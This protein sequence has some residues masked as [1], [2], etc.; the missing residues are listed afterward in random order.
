[1]N[2]HNMR[3]P[4]GDL[5]KVVPGS[6]SG[7]NEGS[8]CRQADKGDGQCRNGG[9][10]ASEHVEARALFL[11][12]NISSK[13]RFSLR[14]P[15]VVPSSRC[16]RRRADAEARRRTA[17]ARHDTNL[18]TGERCPNESPLLAAIL[19]D[20]TNL[21][22]SRR[23]AASQGVT[24]TNSPGRRMPL[25][26]S[27]HPIAHKQLVAAAYASNAVSMDGDIQQ[28]NLNGFLTSEPAARGCGQGR[29]LASSRPCMM[30]SFHRNQSFARAH[31]RPTPTRP[32]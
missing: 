10:D 32:D 26:G 30:A 25:S 29:R 6:R 14:T 3:G 7:W 11:N 16:R 18:R 4:P 12:S 2:A 20:A 19:A 1:M 5:A 23:A 28:D 22:L 8:R 17:H 27:F 31:R 15:R 9:R 21:G 24:A 13:A